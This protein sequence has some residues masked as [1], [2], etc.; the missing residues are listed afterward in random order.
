[1]AVSAGTLTMRYELERP[2]DGVTL[3]VVSFVPRRAGTERL[4]TD[5]PVD[6]A[7]ASGGLEVPVPVPGAVVRAVLGVGS[8]GGFRPLTVAWVYG[9][10]ASGLSLEFTPPGDEPRALRSN[11]EAALRLARSA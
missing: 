2:T 10:G 11:L 9:A 5:V 3:R 4:A 1:V 7:E 8:D 6:A